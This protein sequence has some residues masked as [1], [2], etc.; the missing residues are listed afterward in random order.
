MARFT[1]A[2]PAMFGVLLLGS[3]SLV[4]CAAPC[5]D[6]CAPQGGH[7]SV[8]K[9]MA[10]PHH[11]VHQRWAAW[12]EKHDYYIELPCHGYHPTCWRPWDCCPC[13]TPWGCPEMDCEPCGTERYFGVPLPIAG[14]LIEAGAPVN[15]A[16]APLPAAPSDGEIPPPEG[17]GFSSPMIDEAPMPNFSPL[18]EAPPSVE[19]PPAVPPKTV[20]PA[21]APPSALPPAAAPMP[22]EAPP[23]AAPPTATEGRRYRSLLDPS[24]RS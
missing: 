18:P 17:G 13:P 6:P 21:A 24:F 4:G 12:H 19:P 20:P 7:H 23:T 9:A 16:P 5:C 15:A 11:K 14:E 22:L 10:G 8:R 1:P 3:M 2:R